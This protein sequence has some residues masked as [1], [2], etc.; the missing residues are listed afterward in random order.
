MVG[1]IAARM[2]GEEPTQQIREDLHRLKQVLE[3]GSPQ[4]A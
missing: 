3:A 1:A 2:F 4:P